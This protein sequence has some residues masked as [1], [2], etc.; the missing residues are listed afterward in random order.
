M[1]FLME[2]RR[3]KEWD[4]GCSDQLEYLMRRFGSQVQRLAYY[5]LRDQYL[6][7]DIAQEVFYRV[8]KNLDKFR[9]DSS[10]FTWIYRITVNL[11]RDHL[12]SAAFRR[13]IPWG[14][15][16][17]LEK[18]RA[19]FA[20]PPEIVEGGEVFQRVMELPL[21]YRMVV[22]LYYFQELNVAEIA[23][24]LDIT[25]G[26]VRTRLCRARAVLKKSLGGDIDG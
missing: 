12:G 13:L 1:T 6:A 16:Q 4:E 11:C 7:E 19:G 25:P 18:I 5:Y 2:S 9:R 24:I 20:K 3:E 15:N 23:Q 21:K 10:Y 22:A 17:A 8:Y 14:D 26:N